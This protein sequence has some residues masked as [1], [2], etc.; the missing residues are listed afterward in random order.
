MT[1]PD[2]LALLSGAA[3]G[4]VLAVIGGGGSIL[5]TPALL[6][7]VGMSDAHAAI[8]TSA[9]AVSANALANL[10]QHARR[11]HVM[12]RYGAIFAAAGVVG[13]AFGAGV[14]QHT[15]TKVLLPLFALLM[16][17]IGVF[18]LRR[19]PEGG[20]A[21]ARFEPHKVGRLIATG[22][23]VGTLSGFFGIGGGF[24]IVPGLI[25]ATAMS[26]IQAIGTS[27]LSVSAF[28][29]TTAA[30]YAFGGLIDWR[31]AALFIGGGIVGGAIGALFAARLAQQRGAL[32]RIFALVVFAVAAYMLYRSFAHI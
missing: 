7:L 31:I 18:M 25:G 17:V 14:G 27:L 8:G 5:A 30:T 19:K 3:V 15:D 2:L 9:I 10:V 6:Y 28:G 1:L 13:A 21:I 16:I 26:M 32:Q 29:A 22:A 11:G 4:L 24:L 20:D 23:C 12:W